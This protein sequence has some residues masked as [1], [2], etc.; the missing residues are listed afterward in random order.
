M[1]LH[2]IASVRWSPMIGWHSPDPIAGKQ[3][4]LIVSLIWS[5]VEFFLRIVIGCL[6]GMKRRLLTFLQEK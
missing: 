1:E 3:N 6:A 2:E 5:C 4:K